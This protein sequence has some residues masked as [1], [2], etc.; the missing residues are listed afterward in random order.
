MTVAKE[1][2]ESNLL[3]SRAPSYSQVL[4]TYFL[5]DL[6][7]LP[8]FHRFVY[9]AW[10]RKQGCWLYRGTGI[11][12][13]KYIFRAVNQENNCRDPRARVLMREQ[14][15]RWHSFASDWWVEEIL[16]TNVNRSF[17]RELSFF[18]SQLLNV[19]FTHSFNHSF[20]NYLSSSSCVL[21]TKVI[22]T[23]SDFQNLGV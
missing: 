14:R 1:A 3:A 6:L 21:C 10:H 7:S 12:L 16:F 19:Y 20:N 9:C 23:E 15:G 2:W 17:F 4:W 8:G 5:E 11:L 13:G 22:K 18:H